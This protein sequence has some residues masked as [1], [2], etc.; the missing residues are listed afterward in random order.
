VLE[1]GATSSISGIN[2]NTHQQCS[3]SHSFS[4]YLSL[5]VVDGAAVATGIKHDNDNSN[6][7]R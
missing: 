4:R 2:T 1:A 7:I 5:V 6:N 3:L